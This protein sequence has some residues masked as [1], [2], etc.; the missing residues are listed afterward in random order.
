MT[1]L[2][3]YNKNKQILDERTFEYDARGSKV[4]RFVITN[5][6]IREGNTNYESDGNTSYEYDELNQLTR[7]CQQVKKI[8][9]QFAF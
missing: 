6:K 9:Q 7:Q 4:K 1:K 5:E 3:H 8:S 2:I